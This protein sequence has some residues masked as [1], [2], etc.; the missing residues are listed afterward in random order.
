MDELTEIQHQKNAIIEGIRQVLES[1]D[2]PHITDAISK[3]I[4]QNMNLHFDK[5]VGA[6]ARQIRLCFREEIR[7]LV[8]RA[9]KAEFLKYGI[10]PNRKPKFKKSKS[11][12]TQDIPKEGINEL[13]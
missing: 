5:F 4:H 10:E 8:E 1:K 12:T 11:Q 9:I 13:T 2:L 6:I 3:G 7:G